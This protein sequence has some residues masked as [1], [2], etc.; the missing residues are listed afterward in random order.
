MIP[1]MPNDKIST[2][3]TSDALICTYAKYLV[4]HKPTQTINIISCR[5]RQL[6]RLLLKLQDTIGIDNLCDALK[7]QYFS[8][9]VAA[10][11]AICECEQET[12]TSETIG[13]LPLMGSMLRAVCDVAST[14]NES[15]KSTKALHDIKK[16]RERINVDWN[17]ALD[18]NQKETENVE[19]DSGAVEILV[20]LDDEKEEREKGEETVYVTVA[21]KEIEG[22]Y[23]VF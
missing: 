1:I 8:D 2:V 21:D 12:E 17:T 4:R 13:L 16:L 19:G 18:S 7:P 23:L 5:M 9:I 11:K 6:A 22:M 10:T 20:F 14:M 3:A 15:K